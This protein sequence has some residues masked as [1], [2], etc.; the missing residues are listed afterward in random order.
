MA[1]ST[2]KR[3]Y[4]LVSGTISKETGVTDDS[5]TRFVNS[6]H[7]FGDLVIFQCALQLSSGAFSTTYTTICTL[8]SGFRPANN[9][10]TPAVVGTSIWGYNSKA[11]VYIT[12]DGTVAIYATANSGAG[13][14]ASC[15]HVQFCVAFIGA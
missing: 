7:R 5:D 15:N 9:V 8:P 4:A 6:L 11:K 2:I 14:S 13:E 1:V 12:T 3:E 10:M